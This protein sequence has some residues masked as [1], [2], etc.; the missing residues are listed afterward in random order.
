VSA[1]VPDASVAEGSA[2][3]DPVTDALFISSL[4][5]IE[6]LIPGLA[7]VVAIALGCR[8]GWLSG[9]G[10]LA[11]AS[12]AYINFRWL[13]NTVT[14]LADAVTQGGVHASKPSV[15]LRFLARFV[16]IALAAYVIFVSYPV[17]FHGFLG[18]LFVPILAIFVEATYA[19]YTAIRR[20]FGLPPG[21]MKR[22]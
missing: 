12:V 19:V 14:A 9:L 18:G 6:R 2:V 7:L 11:G 8:A 16:L 1:P 13:K 10:F 3:S 17:A 21:P 4:R 22:R 20:G 5:R 15:I